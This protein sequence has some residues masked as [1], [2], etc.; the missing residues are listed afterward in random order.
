MQMTLI[1][2]VGKR[3]QYMENLKNKETIK[4]FIPYPTGKPLGQMIK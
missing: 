1:N 2:L 4:T 3:V